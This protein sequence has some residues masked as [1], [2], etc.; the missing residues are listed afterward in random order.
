MIAHTASQSRRLLA[1]MEL[2]GAALCFGLMAILTRRLTL[3]DMGFSAGHLAVLRFVVGALVSLAVFGLVPGLYRP[4]NHRLLVARGLSG[5]AV[6]ALYFYALAHIPAGEAGILYNIYPVIATALS[7][8][9]LRE[10]PSVHLWLALLTASLGVMLV[11][12]QGH[13]G[14]GIR[15]G[16]G[17]LAAL[18]A[19]VF[20]A[21]SANAIRAVRHSDNAATIYFYFCLAGLPVVLPFA[22]TPLP[23]GWMPWGLAG[24]MSL[25]AYAGQMLMSDAYGTLS[26]SEASVWLQLLP[27]F[28]FLLAV[29]LLGERV[30]SWGLAGVLITVAGVAYGTAFG[31]RRRM[32]GGPQA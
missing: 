6:V 27:I 32:D 2:A 23:G 17:E 21:T 3:P 9:L 24:L 7:L 11:L 16:A 4:S 13:L 25:L 26:V 19:A 18:G 31:A 14:A 15:L 12:G 8:V 1:R 5:G 10:R 29:P 30:S 22:L 28:Q 20:A